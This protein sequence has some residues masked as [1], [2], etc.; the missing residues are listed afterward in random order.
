MDQTVPVVPMHE[1]LVNVPYAQ[2]RL[3]G[4]RF[5]CVLA[6]PRPSAGVG[7]LRVV[8]AVSGVDG[9]ELVLTY[10]AFVRL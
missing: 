8:R 6:P 2:L 7:T 9:T 4:E 10:A 3:D 1:N 5:V